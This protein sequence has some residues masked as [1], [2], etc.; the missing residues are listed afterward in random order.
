MK[1]F[2]LLLITTLLAPFVAS[3]QTAESD[4][5]AVPTTVAQPSF[6]EVLTS[7]DSVTGATVTIYQDPLL[8][9][10]ISTPHTGDKSMKGYRVQIFS[11]N[12]QKSARDKAF[13]IEKKVL[14]R[15]P[16]LAIYV[17]YNAP[18]WK[19]RVGDCLTH[20]AAA[21]LRQFLITA[22]PEL[23]AETYIVP[24]KIIIK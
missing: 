19:V 16:E 8:E 18:F 1:K 2:L 21:Q 5:L 22:F 24:D 15:F 20:N 7:P 3:A 10:L 6:I 13:G 12:H 23:Q 9:K 4:T 17:T 14:Q 11:S